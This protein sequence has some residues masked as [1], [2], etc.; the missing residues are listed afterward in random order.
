MPTITFLGAGSAVFTRELLADI[1]GFPELAG[2]RIVLHDIDAERLEILG[3][4]DAIA[5]HELSNDDSTGSERA[6]D[7]QI[8]RLCRK[9]E[10]DPSNPVYLQ[11]VRS[12]GYIL[13]TD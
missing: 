2:A 4:A 12:K 8:N 3:A 7:V 1:L 13:Y 6:I 11:T 9:I 5:R 10:S